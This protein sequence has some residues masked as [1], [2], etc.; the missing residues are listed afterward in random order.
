ML[1]KHL[2]GTWTS[3]QFPHPQE[4]QAGK[5]GV[6]PWFTFSAVSSA[7]SVTSGLDLWPLGW[8]EACGYC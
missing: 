4:D 7:P 2:I 1:A 5:S 6:E 8:Q 3:T